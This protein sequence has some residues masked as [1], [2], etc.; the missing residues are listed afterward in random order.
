VNLAGRVDAQTVVD[1]RHEIGGRY[2][3]LGGS[4]GDLVRLSLRALPVA[5]HQSAAAI[6]KT[7]AEQDALAEQVAALAFAVVLGHCRKIDGFTHGIRRK[8]GNRPARLAARPHEP[9]RIPTAAL[10]VPHAVT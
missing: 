1:R 6:E 4:A 8:P 2:R 9:E 5:L 7:P 10:T 3:V